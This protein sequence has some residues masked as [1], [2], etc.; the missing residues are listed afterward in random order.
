MPATLPATEDRKLEYRRALVLAPPN[1]AGTGWV[2]R[3]GPYS[4]GF[5]SGWMRVRGERRRRAYHRGFVISDH[6]D[7]PALIA[8]CRETAA[9]RVLTMHGYSDTLAR[10]L[11]EQGLEARPLATVSDASLH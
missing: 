10:Y 7:W 6:A 1:A 8:T 3:V 4:S 9:R 5:C 11:T 2:R